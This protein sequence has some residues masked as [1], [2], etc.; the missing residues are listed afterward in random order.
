MPAVWYRKRVN[1]RSSAPEQE[2]SCKAHA[3]VRPIIT[4]FVSR[5]HMLAA[6]LNVLPRQWSPQHRQLKVSVDAVTGFPD[7]AMR[8]PVFSFTGCDHYRD[9]ALA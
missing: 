2:S 6:L 5:Q 1:C 4:M 9:T 8:K 3:E 7:R